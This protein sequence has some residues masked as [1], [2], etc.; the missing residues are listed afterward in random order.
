M[1][2]RVS[3]FFS[4]RLVTRRSLQ[5]WRRSEKKNES[6]R[7]IRHYLLSVCWPRSDLWRYNLSL[8][9]S[10][11]GRP[12][13]N[14]PSYNRSSPLLALLTTCYRFSLPILLYFIKQSSSC[15]DLKRGDNDL[16]AVLKISEFCNISLFNLTIIYVYM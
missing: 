7:F 15:V 13:R 3:Y 5:I 4:L 10:S 1:R 11:F 14:V 12:I 2:S 16:L 6:S 8:K 9:L